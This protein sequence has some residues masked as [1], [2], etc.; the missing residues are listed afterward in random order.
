M[1]VGPGNIHAG[2]AGHMN[3]H[4]GGFFAGIKRDGHRA[5]GSRQALLLPLQQ[6]PGGVGFACG[7]GFGWPRKMQMRWAGSGVMMCSNLLA[8]L[9]A[10]EFSNAEVAFNNG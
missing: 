4:R 3:F 9:R 1:P 2:A 6:S 5:S 10:S 7:H 8:W